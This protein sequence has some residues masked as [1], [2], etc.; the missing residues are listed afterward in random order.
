MFPYGNGY[1]PHPGGADRVDMVDGATLNL[2]PR[3]PRGLLGL[4]R[5][6]PCGQRVSACRAMPLSA[7]R[8]RAYQSS[9]AFFAVELRYTQRRHELPARTLPLA[10]C[11]SLF[12]P[13]R[14]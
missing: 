1:E 7:L 3:R 5:P 10:A 11:K 4:T 14:I 9:R 2:K 6:C 8:G 13:P 12:L